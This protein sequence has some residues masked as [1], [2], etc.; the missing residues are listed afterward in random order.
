MERKSKEGDRDGIF[1]LVILASE[2]QSRSGSRKGEWGS[3]GV[4]VLRSEVCRDVVGTMFEVRSTKSFPVRLSYLNMSTFQGVFCCR[5]KDGGCAGLK[6]E[7][8][9]GYLWCC[10]I[11]EFPTREEDPNGCFDPNCI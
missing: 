11:I 1:S 7:G 6:S 4:G 5:G 9:P 8:K 10:P 2:R 3:G